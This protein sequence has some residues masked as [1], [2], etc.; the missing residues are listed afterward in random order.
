V[1]YFERLQAAEVRVRAEQTSQAAPPTAPEPAA[2]DRGPGGPWSVA[3]YD[4]V[5]L[6][7]EPVVRRQEETLDA[8]WGWDSPVAAIPADDFSAAWTREVEL[9]GGRYLFSTYSDDGVRL[10]VD[11]EPIISSWRPMRGY[12]KALVELDEGIHTV[13]LEY[14]ER[15]GIA[16]VRLDWRRQ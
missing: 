1:E 14:F 10:F 11:G 15:G 3:Y 12:R 5:R 8:N 13:R 2:D 7:G 4:N 9:S 6:A 16:L